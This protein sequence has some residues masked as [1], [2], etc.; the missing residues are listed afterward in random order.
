MRRAAPEGWFASTKEKAIEGP[1]EDFFDELACPQGKANSG[2]SP[3][4]GRSPHRIRTPGLLA[5]RWS[6]S[7]LCQTYTYMYTYTYTYFRLCLG[8]LVWPRFSFFLFFPC[9]SPLFSFSCLFLSS[10]FRVPFSFFPFVL[11][12]FSLGR[13]SISPFFLFLFPWPRPNFPLLLFFCGPLPFFPLLR[14]KIS[15]FLFPFFFPLLFP[16]QAFSSFLFLPSLFSLS[17]SFLSSFL[18]SFPFAA[19][20]LLFALFVLVLFFPWPRLSLSSGF[21]GFGFLFPSFPPSSCAFPCPFFP[22]NSSA[23]PKTPFRAFPRFFSLFPGLFFF[24][25]LFPFPFFSS[26]PFFSA[27]L[28]SF[29][30][31]CFL[32][33]VLAPLQILLLFPRISSSPVSRAPFS[34]PQFL[35]ALLLLLPYSSSPTVPYIRPNSLF[36]LL[37]QYPDG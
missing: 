25:F 15:F 28:S 7:G 13:A 23:P 17:S 26:A 35:F 21:G 37:S 5:G 20:L 8:S 18:F 34:P 31:Y 2:K 33:H 1:G 12:L 3:G 32:T 24:F 14:P 10:F 11:A 16:S 19:S 27:P 30:P 9:P 6:V 22:Q 4:G 36:K 29:C